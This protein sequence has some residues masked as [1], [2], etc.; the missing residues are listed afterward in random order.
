M[1]RSS[2]ETAD[3]TGDGLAKVLATLARP[4]RM[5]VLAA[6]T[7]GPTYVSQLARDLGISRALLQVHRKRLQTVGLISHHI[8]TGLALFSERPAGRV[9]Q[10]IR[11]G[12]L[13]RCG[14]GGRPRR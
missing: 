13:W 11:L 5:R 8:A 12:A 4:H 2:M 9:A 14:S 1:V 3:L 6:L 7:T 10:G